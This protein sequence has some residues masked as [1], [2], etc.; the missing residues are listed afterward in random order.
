M[1]LADLGIAEDVCVQVGKFTFPA[2]FVVVDYDIDPCVPLILW[3]PFLRTAHSLVD[4]YGEELI[5]RDGDEKFI[6]H[7][8]STSNILINMEM[9]SSPKD[10]I[11]KI[12]SILEELADEPSLVDSFPSEKDDYLFENDNDEW[13]NILYRDLFDNNHSEKD[14]IKESK[15]KILIDELE[16]PKSNV[17]PPQLLDCDLTLHEE[18][19]EIDTLPSFPSGN[20]DKVC[21]PGILVYGSTHFVTN[22]VTQ[23]KNLKKKTSS[24]VLLIIEDSNF[25]PFS[26]DRELLFH[27]E[28]FVTETLHHFHLKMGTKFSIP[29]YSFQKEFTLSL[30]DYLVGPIKFS[31]SLMFI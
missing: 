24:E 25:L 31:R 5:L 6:F 17:L 23:D 28:L 8:D 3:R 29:G 30:W 14:K 15:M 9:N 27:L 21:N 1:A 7:A 19:T 10:N 11:E 22:E 12:D 20:K 16:T 13:R 2:D 18:F 4:V 26:S